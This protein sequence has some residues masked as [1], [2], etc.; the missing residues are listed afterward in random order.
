MDV[1]YDEYHIY[2]KVKKCKETGEPCVDRHYYKSRLK[3]AE[4]EKGGYTFVGYAV[5]SNR[6]FIENKKRC[7]ESE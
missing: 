6:Y 1:V 2:T 7:I 4:E 3:Q 5:L